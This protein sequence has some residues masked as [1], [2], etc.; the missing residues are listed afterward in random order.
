MS[1]IMCAFVPVNSV[2]VM[3]HKPM[4]NPS[5]FALAGRF[6]G[7]HRAPRHAHHRS[8]SQPDGRPGVVRGEGREDGGSKEKERGGEC[9]EGCMDSFFSSAALP[10]S[11]PTR[12]RCR[13]FGPS[14]PEPLKPFDSHPSSPGTPR[15]TSSRRP[16]P[17]R[18]GAGATSSSARAPTM[19]ARTQS[20]STGAAGAPT[21][22]SRF[23]KPGGISKNPEGPVV[24]R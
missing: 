2:P 17:G 24:L 3:H 20:R 23:R 4:L 5:W 1:H 6:D 10:Q 8:H 22:V 7:G 21:R 12:K 13:V 11:P 19:P 15:A 18:P 16:P 14:P 9:A